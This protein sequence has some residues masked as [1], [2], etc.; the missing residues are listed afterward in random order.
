MRLNQLAKIATVAATT[1][2][3]AVLAIGPAAAAPT[4]Q[5]WVKTDDSVC[6]GTEHHVV[7]TKVLFQTCMVI[8]YSNYTAQPVLVVRNNASV[9]ITMKSG[10]T[11]SNWGGSNTYCYDK[12]LAAGQVL[13]CYG[14]S[15]PYIDGENISWGGFTYNGQ[16][17]KTLNLSQ[18]L[19]RP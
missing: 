12:V 2:S 19:V 4:W 18:Y 17:D 7:S 5:P 14:E 10:Y 9:S 16:S 11:H 15:A 6:G 13:A 1:V 8:N 3:A